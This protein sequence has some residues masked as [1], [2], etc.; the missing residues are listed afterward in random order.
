MIYDYAPIQGWRDFTHAVFTHVVFNTE[1]C[2]ILADNS[3]CPNRRAVLVVQWIGKSGSRKD[4]K[5]VGKICPPYTQ[6]TQD[7]SQDSKTEEAKRAWGTGP[8]S[9]VWGTKSLKSWS[10]L[11]MSVKVELTKRFLL[12]I[13]FNINITFQ[14]QQRMSDNNETSGIWRLYYGRPTE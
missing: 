11:T 10:I 3:I 7:R 6:V 12:K 5:Y 8:G 4:F 1:P 13:V 14:F 9:S 2:K